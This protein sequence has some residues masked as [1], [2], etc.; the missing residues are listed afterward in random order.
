MSRIAT[1]SRVR[2]KSAPTLDNLSITATGPDHAGR[3][4]TASNLPEAIRVPFLA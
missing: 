2:K 3:R 4:P 1:D